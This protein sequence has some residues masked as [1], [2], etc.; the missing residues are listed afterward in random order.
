MNCHGLLLIQVKIPA[1]IDHVNVL[2]ANLLSVRIST[3]CDNLK[4]A[5][6]NLSID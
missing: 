4:I 3:V 5:C 2:N 1:D 6:E